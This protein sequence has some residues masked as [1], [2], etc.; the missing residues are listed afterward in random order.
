MLTD[1][2]L[3]LICPGEQDASDESDSVTTSY[4]SPTLSAS[5]K[6]FSA[7]LKSMVWNEEG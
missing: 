5:D 4:A 6:S 3:Q 2:A 1:Q 7:I